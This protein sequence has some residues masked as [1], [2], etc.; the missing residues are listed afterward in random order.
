M[1]HLPLECT[2]GADE[3]DGTQPTQPEPSKSAAPDWRTTVNLD[4]IGDA[5]LRKRVIEMLETHQDMW[6][7][8]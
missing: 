3:T 4:R 7:S 8:G 6:T 1:L 2:E 5:D